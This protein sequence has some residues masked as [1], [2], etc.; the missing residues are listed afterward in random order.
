MKIKN[1]RTDPV[2]LNESTLE[3]NIVSEICALFNY[4]NGVGYSARLNWIFGI[5]HTM[6][7]IP[8]KRKAKIY[9]L[10]PIEEHD[11][12]G[13]DSKLVIPSGNNS[14]RA[15]FIQFKAGKNNNGNN[16]PSSIF[17]INIKNPNKHV[18]FKFNDNS[19]NSQ[20]QTLK[21]LQDTLISK[22]LPAKSVLYG[23]PRITDLNTFDNL[24][25]ELL[26]HTTFLTLSEIETNAKAK[27][28][29]LNDGNPH[30]FRA[31][32]FD[33]KKREISSDPFQLNYS[34]QN[35][36]FLTEVVLV[37]YINWRNQFYN[38]LPESLINEE[39]LFMMSDFLK[40]NPFKLY[41]FRNYDFPRRFNR[42]IESYYKDLEL[43]S[44]NYLGNLFGP[45]NSDFDGFS[46]RKALFK[47]IVAFLSQSDG[48]NITIDNDVPSE[49]S[50]NL[51]NDI[52]INMQSKV[53]DPINL[54]VF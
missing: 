45:N 52:E 33:E 38:E 20:H 27:K 50:F 30:Y 19:D 49:F 4:S 53:I 15:V 14:S 10:T 8:R 54:L 31:C 51:N 2:S 16:I 26:L 5:P 9:R 46:W 37:N 29:N 40:I 28:I 24:E 3:T 7:S 32:Y 41:E 18:E 22:G 39:F 11:G 36:D 42:E 43:K 1:V 12:G 21:N 47:R 25:E 6:H 48:K 44:K 34:E 17:N 13:W 23:F 35:S